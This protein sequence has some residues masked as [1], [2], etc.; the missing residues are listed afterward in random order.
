MFQSWWEDVKDMWDNLTITGKYILFP[1]WLILS[2]LVLI[3]GGIFV[4]YPWILYEK[5]ID[6]LTVLLFKR[7]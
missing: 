1:F 7:D 4:V 5:I 6:Y 2:I 3:V